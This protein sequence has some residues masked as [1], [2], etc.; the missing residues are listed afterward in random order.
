MALKLYTVKIFYTNT[1]KH[2]S[3]W[4]NCNSNGVKKLEYFAAKKG[5]AYIQLFKQHTTNVVPLQ[6]IYFVDVYICTQYFY[7]A[8]KNIKHYNIIDLES[9]YK[10]AYL[11]GAVG[12]NVYNLYTKRFHE[13]K[14]F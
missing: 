14:K 9:Y 12:V 13:S 7:D 5:F 10:N 8:T 11:C 3:V 1:N 2:F 4:H 6:T